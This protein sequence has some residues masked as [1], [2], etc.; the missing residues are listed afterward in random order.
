MRDLIVFGEDFNGLPSST[1]HLVKHLSTTRKILWVNSIGLRKPK[2][3]INDAKRAIGKLFG[4]SKSDFRGTET[5]ST[6]PHNIDVVNVRTIPA[7]SR[8]WER[9]LAKSL[10]RAQLVPK[11]EKLQLQAPILWTSL[12]T[13]ADL[14][15]QLGD[16][17]VVYYCGDDFGALAGVDHDTVTTHEQ[18]LSNKADLILV[19]SAKV[20]QKFPACKTTLIQHGVDFERFTQPTPRA[21]DLPQGKPIAGFYG[22]LS[23]WLDYPLLNQLI[24]NMPD[25][26]FVFIGKNEL[27]HSPLNPAPNLHLLGPKPHSALPSYSQHWQVSLLPFLDTPQIQACSPLKLL[28]YIAAGNPVVHTH[29]DAAKPYLYQTNLANNAAQFERALRTYQDLKQPQPASIQ[30]DS[31]SSRAQFVDWL[32]ELL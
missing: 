3:T 29:F 15:G 13:A 18:E 1:Q 22:S 9:Q 11:I 21:L 4:A 8:H 19:A 24:A 27:S 28:E 17:N 12:P 5:S 6:T 32:L 30:Q 14:C 16:T 31:W 10:I 23:K 25:W 7:P 26:N 20:Q 2:L